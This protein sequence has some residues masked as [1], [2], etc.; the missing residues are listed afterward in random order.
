MERQCRRAAVRR[1]GVKGHS[2]RVPTGTERGVPR[3]IRTDPLSDLARCGRA[4]SFVF[5]LG[6]TAGGGKK[7]ALEASG[8]GP[9]VVVVDRW[10]TENA[11]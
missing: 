7:A 5:G 10:W 11:D 4:N 3:G 8:G 2:A 1:G 6:R 9:V